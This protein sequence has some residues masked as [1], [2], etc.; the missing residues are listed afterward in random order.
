M[1]ELERTIRGGMDP[2]IAEIVEEGRVR[3]ANKAGLPVDATWE[4]II[5]D[6]PTASKQ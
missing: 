6:D 1:S 3:Q 4:D 2:K 5:M